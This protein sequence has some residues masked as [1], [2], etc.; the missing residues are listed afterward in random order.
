MKKTLHT[1]WGT[2]KIS[3]KG[4]FTITSR[5]EG[6]HGEKLHRLIAKD[7]FGDWIDEPDPNGDKWV[8]HHVNG[9]KT[10]NCV[11]NLEPIPERDHNV[12]HNSGENHHFYGKHLSDEHKHKLS[13]AFKGENNP[14]YGKTG[15]WKNK[16]FSDEHKRK[17]SI[18][19]NTSGYLYV[20]KQ[21][22]KRCKQGFIWTYKYYDENGK[23]KSISSI[24]IKK[25]KKKVKAKGLEWR[26]I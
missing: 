26:E 22:T 6:N 12:L 9:D 23:R 15:Y 19:M 8:I 16:S 14:N 10:C 18:T 4:Y 13:E 25:L 7:Y 11:L 5:K 21:K 20:Y 2:A 17:I 3:T 1:K 24:D